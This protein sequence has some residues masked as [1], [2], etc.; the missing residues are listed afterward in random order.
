MATAP[1]A[2]RQHIASRPGQPAARFPRVL[3]ACCACR[4]SEEQQRLLGELMLGLLQ[5]EGQEGELEDEDERE[6]EVE[7]EKKER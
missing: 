4:Y 6:E 5:Q 3:H 7:E 2:Q 1:P